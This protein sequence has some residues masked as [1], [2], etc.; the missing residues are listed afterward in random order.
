M[1]MAMMIRDA[2]GDVMIT[3][4]PLESRGFDYHNG[5]AFSIFSPGIRGELGRGGRYQTSFSPRGEVST[6]V[7]LY[8][9]RVLRAVPKSEDMDVVYIPHDAGLSAWREARASGHICRFGAAGLGDQDARDADMAAMK[10]THIW[11]NGQIRPLK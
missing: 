6:G 2:F 8:L 5:I 1:A 3:I 7:T 9:E 10:A 4:D 11:D